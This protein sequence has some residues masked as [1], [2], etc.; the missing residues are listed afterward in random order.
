[1]WYINIARANI[2]LH[3]YFGQN[4]NAVYYTRKQKMAIHNASSLTQWQTYVYAYIYM[5]NMA[6]ERRETESHVPI[7]NQTI[8]WIWF[9]LSSSPPPYGTAHPPYD[10]ISYY[11]SYYSYNLVYS[12][13]YWITLCT[14]LPNRP[15]YILLLHNIW[16]TRT[17]YALS[18]G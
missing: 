2:I 10:I 4:L 1:M 7:V 12:R 14:L 15:S 16:D 8:P 9:V 5:Y 6:R 13:L 11:I 17:L 3:K 18:Y